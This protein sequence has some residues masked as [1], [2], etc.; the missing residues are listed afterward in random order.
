MN[1]ASWDKLMRIKL[2]DGDDSL[3]PQEEKINYEK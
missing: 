3:R 2:T 1:E